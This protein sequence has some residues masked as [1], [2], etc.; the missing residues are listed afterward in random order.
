MSKKKKIPVEAGVC[1]KCGGELAYEE[2]WVEDDLVG[3]AYRCLDCKVDGTEWYR[4]KFSSHA[5]FNRKTKN[6]DRF[7]AKLE[8]III[9]VKGGVATCEENPTDNPVVIRD[10][11]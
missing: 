10:L 1:P 4:T 7:N 6:Y 11:D 9:E 8:P 3:R 5:I 2:E